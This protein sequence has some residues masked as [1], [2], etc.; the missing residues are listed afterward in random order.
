MS[1]AKKVARAI[2]AADSAFEKIIERSPL[3][4]IGFSPDNSSRKRS[5]FTSLV[6]SVISQQLSTKA[7]ATIISRVETLAGGLSPRSIA[8]L[9][10]AHLRSV[11]VSSAKARSL[12][13]LSEVFLNRRSAIHRLDQLTDGE[14]EDVLLPIFGIGRWTIEMFLMFS[15]ER[16]DVWPV[17]DL[18]VRRGWEK[19]HRM[20]TEITPQKLESLG[21]K[22]SPYR[23]HAAWY[24]WRAIELL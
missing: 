20:R 7:A 4:P 19:L 18:G 16:I 10:E 1:S 5:P 3:C 15:L 9:S 2:V 24:C 12:H 21:E 13:E 11:G 22:F 6:H 8:R 23:S 14:I 17:G